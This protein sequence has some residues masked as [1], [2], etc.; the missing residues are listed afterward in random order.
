MLSQR[1]ETTKAT[2]S[3]SDIYYFHFLFSKELIRQTTSLPVK[4]VEIAIKMEKVATKLSLLCNLIDININRKYP[5]KV[6]TL[7]DLLMR[8]IF[9]KC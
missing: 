9:R 7:T 5:G 2:F 1:G 4:S 3:P 6:K 8:G